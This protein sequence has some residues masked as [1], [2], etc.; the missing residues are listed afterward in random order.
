[1]SKHVEE[2]DGK[3]KKLLENIK[4]ENQLKKKTKMWYVMNKEI[5]EK[6]KKELLILRDKVR[7]WKQGCNEFCE[8]GID[9][10]EGL[11]LKDPVALDLYFQHTSI[12]EK[13][14]EMF[15]KI[16]KDEN[17]KPDKVEDR[18]QELKDMFEYMVKDIMQDESYPDNKRIKIGE[19]INIKGL[20]CKVIVKENVNIVNKD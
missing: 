13:V 14:S 15:D 10:V 18:I 11:E 8:R 7:I 16:I 17:V 20:R 6:Y 2:K 9:P 3:Q 4:E 12:V 1:M 5:D 19:Y